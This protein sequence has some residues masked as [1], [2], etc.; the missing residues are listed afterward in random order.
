M[1]SANILVQA[2]GKP[3]PTLRGSETQNQ[4]WH[5]FSCL[6]MK[7]GISFI[8]FFSRINAIVIPI[9]VLA[10]PGQYSIHSIHQAKP[11]P[12]QNFIRA[13]GKKSSY[14]LMSLYFWLRSTNILIVNIFMQIYSILSARMRTIP[15]ICMRAWYC[16]RIS[17]TWHQSKSERTECKHK[18]LQR[19]HTYQKTICIITHN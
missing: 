7:C 1:S 18:K 4:C 19:T 11:Q 8:S 15:A 14:S 12:I 10:N 16:V 5:L 2:Q 13:R 9:A 6:L 17:H 3:G